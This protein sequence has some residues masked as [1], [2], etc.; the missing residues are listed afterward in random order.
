M[1]YL[2]MAEIALRGRADLQA[3]IGLKITDR[4]ARL[5]NG[6][7]A[8]LARHR[9]KAAGMACGAVGWSSTCVDGA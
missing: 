3:K 8:R 9:R 4:K 5:A 7:R 2:D 1:A 6:I